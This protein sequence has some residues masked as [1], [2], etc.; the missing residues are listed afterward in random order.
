MRMNWQLWEGVLSKE[1]CEDVVEKCKKFPLT[2]GTVFSSTD[3]KPDLSVRSTKLAFVNDPDIIKTINYYG[4]S[5]N[6]AVYN[7]NVDYTPPVQFGEY[8]S[9]SFYSWHHDINWQSD[10]MYDRKLSIVIQLSN[11][12]DYEG[13][14]FEFKNIETPQA[15]KT[16]GS[17]L[18]FP[19]YNE[20]RVTEITK[21]TRHSLVCWLEGPR[22]R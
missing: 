6:R 17:V 22:W 9:G 4:Y 21:G 19:S 12:K 16:Q 20:H 18:V 8:S 15:F 2:D 5:A 3:Y 7:F 11:P 1:W 14:A 10:S 13:G